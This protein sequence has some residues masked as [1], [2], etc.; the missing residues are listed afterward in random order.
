MKTQEIIENALKF[1]S[2]EYKF[3]YEYESI[4]NGAEYFKYTN[5]YGNF[6]YYQWLQFGEKQFSVKYNQTFK[7]VDLQLQFSKEFVC[8]K[9]THSGITWWFKDKRKEY[10]NMIAS[11][12]KKEIKHS[13]TLFGLP[14]ER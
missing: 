13:N 1:L 14:I 4:Y 6:V 2:V 8:F 11:I 7:V 5:K 12:I 9:K 3:F 10:W